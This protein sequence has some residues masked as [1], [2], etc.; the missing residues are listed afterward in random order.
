M[1]ARALA[2]GRRAPP[3]VLL[4]AA[5][6]VSA[7]LYVAVLLPLRLDRH[8]PSRTFNLAK[9]LGEDWRGLAGFT[10][11]MVALFGLY[12][13]GV[14]LVRRAGPHGAV[15][16]LVFGTVFA[17]LLLPAHPWYS[18]DVFHYIATARVLYVHGHNPLVTPPQAFPAD[19]LVQLPDWGWLPSPYGPLWM[20]LSALPAAVARGSGAATAGL[21]GFKA[22][23][24]AC[25]LGTAWLAGGVAERLRPGSRAVAVLLVAWNPLAV[26]H[27]AADGHNDV[28]MLL[29]VMAALYLAVRGRAGWATVALTAA[30]LVKFVPVLLVPL[31]VTWL[32]RSARPHRRRE[33]ALIPV[34]LL[35]LAV[36]AYAP[37]WQGPATLRSSLNEGHYLTTSVHALVLPVV[38]HVLSRAAAEA[39]LTW[40]A[41]LAFL[42]I[43]MALALRVGRPPASLAAVSAAALALYLV[44]AS[45]WLMPWYA[46]WPLPL[47]ATVPWR[48]GVLLPVL[49]LTFGASLMPV[50][51]NYLSGMSDAGDSW[52]PMHAVAVALVL[53][54]PALAWWWTA[55]PHPAPHPRARR[56]VAGLRGFSGVIQSGLRQRN[57]GRAMTTQE[58]HTDQQAPPISFTDTAREKVKAFMASKDKEGAALRIGIQGRTSQGF[59]YAMNIVDADDHDGMDVELDGGGFTVLVDSASLENLRGAMI[60]FVES[61]QGA[62]FQIENPNPVW[63][64]ETALL[65]QNIIDTQINPGV[66]SHGGYVELLDVKDGIAYVRLGGGCQGCGLADVTLKQGIEAMIKES[67][68]SITAVMDATDHASGT[69]PYYRPSK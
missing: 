10:V 19:T 65:V 12:A 34:V 35:G 49:A 11:L 44:V 25:L 20:L 28:A 54:P 8:P 6:G 13:A 45:P 3:A 58:T 15:I 26:L 18:A 14:V 60:D 68:P 61:A 64:D 51:T 29:P 9:A 5:G 52:G 16:A 40:G 37:F 17:A 56:R 50:A 21:I 69:N 47:A 62:G 32:L 38:A 22:L 53:G 41:R 24:A 66:A 43:Y 67:V 46:L 1:P 42:P 59:R 36:A 2:P 55:R 33:A 48:R 7:L 30:A 57:G 63:A 23:A 27:T 31:F 4:A 39:A